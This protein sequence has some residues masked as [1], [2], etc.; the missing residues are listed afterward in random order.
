M[1]RW[2]KSLWQRFFG[3][4]CEPYKPDPFIRYDADGRSRRL[5]IAD[6]HQQNLC[7]RLLMYAS[8]RRL[9][10]SPVR[11]RLLERAFYRSHMRCASPSRFAGVAW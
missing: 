10:L 11:M 7:V 8:Q 6:L 4:P 2:I 1:I 5:G 9:K 3:K